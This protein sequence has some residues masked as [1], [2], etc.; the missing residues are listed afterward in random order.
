[1]SFSLAKHGDIKGLTI[2]FNNYSQFELIKIVP[3][4]CIYTQHSYY[5]SSNIS[6]VAGRYYIFPYSNGHK[7]LTAIQLVFVHLNGS[8]C[9]YNNLWQHKSYTL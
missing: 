4:A 2:S 3:K 9:S 6:V 1:M 5:D 7:E 8:E